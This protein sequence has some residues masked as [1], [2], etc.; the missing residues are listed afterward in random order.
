MKRRASD[1]GAG[2]T[3]AKA[4]ALG[5]GIAG[6]NA[7]RAGPFV[8]GKWLTPGS[9]RGQGARA[10]ILTYGQQSHVPSKDPDLS[11]ENPGLRSL[12][13]KGG[14]FLSPCQL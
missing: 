9:G 4:K 8:L 14:Q 3:S 10:L 7:K 5:S 2:E 11:V 12:H 1:R 13:S 6:N